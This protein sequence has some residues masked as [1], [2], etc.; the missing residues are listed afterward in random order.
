MV[1]ATGSRSDRASR[2]NGWKVLLGIEHVIEKVRQ[3]VHGHQRN[4][5]HDICVRVAD[6]A[7]RFHIGIT[8]LAAG[9]DDFARKLNSGVPLR[10]ACMTLPSDNDF[11]GRQLGHM[12]GRKA[13][14]RQAVVASIHF[15]DGEADAVTRLYVER[16]TSRAEWPMR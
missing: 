15:G 14:N 4:D 8:D 13:V 5:L 11:I 6:I 10:V 12:L 9:L 7:N 2:R 16:S 1:D 3:R